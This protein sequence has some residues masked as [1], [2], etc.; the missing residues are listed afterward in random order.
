MRV[1]VP[2]ICRDCKHLR[3]ARQGDKVVYFCSLFIFDAMTV[4]ERL[5]R[6]DLKTKD[7]EDVIITIRKVIIDCTAKNKDIVSIYEDE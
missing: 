3:K 4:E 1:D 6:A 2:E 7:G 5:K